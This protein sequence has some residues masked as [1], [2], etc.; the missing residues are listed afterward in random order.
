V[1][2]GCPPGF[3]SRLAAFPAKAALLDPAFQLDSLPK[4]SGN[5]VQY[6]EELAMAGDVTER[7]T[8]LENMNK[9]ALRS[10]WHDFFETAAPHRLR[11]ELMVH[12]LAYRIQEQGFGALKPSTRQRLRQWARSIEN[13]STRAV[14]TA[15]DMKLGTRLVREWR[16]QVHVVE[17]AEQGYEYKGERYASLSEIAR[18]ITGARWSGPL[19]FGLKSKN[20]TNAGASQ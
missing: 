1:T 4:G 12:I 2:L 10:L 3:C 7:I 9:V 15:P 14:A 17:A 18:Q 13:G 5:G 6:K 11:R 8:G 20:K 16:G 19:F